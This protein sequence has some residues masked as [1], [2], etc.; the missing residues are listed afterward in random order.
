LLTL[1]LIQEFWNMCCNDRISRLFRKSCSVMFSGLLSA[2]PC[3]I[4]HR[5]LRIWGGF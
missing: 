4:R 2:A 1:I 3:P 5:L